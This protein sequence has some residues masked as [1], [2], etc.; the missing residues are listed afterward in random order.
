[1]HLPFEGVA[2]LWRIAFWRF[3]RSSAFDTNTLLLRVCEFASN[4][5][6]RQNRPKIDCAIVL[7]LPL[8]GLIFVR[9]III[10][11]RG[12]HPSPEPSTRSR[13]LPTGRNGGFCDSLKSFVNNSSASRFRSK[14]KSLFS[15]SLSKWIL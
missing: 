3:H 5:E 11:G 6:S 1:M 9:D 4:T 2:K 13:P 15:N 8:S 12:H 7:Q 14:N 10:V